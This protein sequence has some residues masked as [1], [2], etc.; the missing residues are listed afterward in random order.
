MLENGVRLVSPPPID[1]EEIANYSLSAG[2]VLFNRTISSALL[3]KTA[4]FRGERAAIYA[5]Y[6]IRVRLRRFGYPCQRYLS[7]RR[8][9][10][11]PKLLR[12]A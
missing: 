8:L 9:F 3:G 12:M 7:N 6:L 1:K 10:G 4:L 2:E 11:A 5:G